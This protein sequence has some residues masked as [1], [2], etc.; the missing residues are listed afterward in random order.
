MPFARILTPAL[1]SLSRVRAN[2]WHRVLDGHSHPGLPD[3]GPHFAWVV[4]N[5]DVRR[6]WIGHLE[7]VAAPPSAAALLTSS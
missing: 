1:R 4:V 7:V 6:I 3:P 5:D 2:Q